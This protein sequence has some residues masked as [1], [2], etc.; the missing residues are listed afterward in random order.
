MYK[1]VSFSLDG[2]YGGIFIIFIYLYSFILFRIS[3]KDHMVKSRVPLLFYF[4]IP[5]KDGGYFTL[6]ESPRYVRAHQGAFV[7]AR[8][9]NFTGGALLFDALPGAW[10][11]KLVRGH[12]RAL[13][14]VR[15]LQPLATKRAAEGY[16]AGHGGVRNALR[17]HLVYAWHVGCSRARAV[18]LCQSPLA[19]RGWRE[20]AAAVPAGGGVDLVGILRRA[21]PPW[22]FRRHDE[23]CHRGLAVLHS[24]G[25]AGVWRY[26]GRLRGEAWWRHR[27]HLV[28]ICRGW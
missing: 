2:M 19:N 6:H 1:S 14:E 23:S 17:V 22:V 11:T 24:L 5:C 28:R 16:A 4:H 15:V 9:I 26:R 27:G 12:R 18:S 20:R 7:A 8:A 3:K 13:H 25:A 10:E 21:V